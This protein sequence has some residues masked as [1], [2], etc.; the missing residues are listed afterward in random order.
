MP[1]SPWGGAHGHPSRHGPAA[2]PLLPWQL[3]YLPQ[4][5]GNCRASVQ[6][7]QMLP[8]YDTYSIAACRLQCEKEAVVRSCHCRMVHMPGEGC[9]WWHGG[10]PLP[11]WSCMGVPWPPPACIQ[12]PPHPIPLRP[13]GPPAPSCSTQGPPHP[14]RMLGQSLSYTP[15]TPGQPLPCPP[16]TQGPP[17]PQ[18]TCSRG[19]PVPIPSTARGHHCPIAFRGVSQGWGAEAGQIPTPLTSCFSAGNE[20][21]CSPNVYIE[22]ADHTLGRCGGGQEAGG[23]PGAP[24]EG[25]GG[26]AALLTGSCPQTP[27]WRTAR[28]AAAA[29]HRAT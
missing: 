1:H 28:S 8:G 16:C 24:G 21:I 7:E 19:P 12:G 18:P 15:Y 22:C 11:R 27:R 4:P 14:L 2:M 13:K 29:P 26:V 25:A 20:S 23:Q 3:T 5:W 17:L 6:G 10:T 9:V